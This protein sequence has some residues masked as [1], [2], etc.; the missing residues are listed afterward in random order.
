[1][2]ANSITTAIITHLSL[3]G[4]VAWRNNNGAIYDPTRK[5]FRKNPQHKL[6][7]PDVIGFN[8]TTG[9]FIAI[10]VKFGKDKPSPAQVRFIDEAT[11][12]GCV[13]FFAYSYD[14]FLTKLKEPCSRQGL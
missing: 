8:K 7:I 2:S 9:Q 13:A 12:A 6:G 10:E 1:M 11:K 14:D 3:D 4:W 5:V